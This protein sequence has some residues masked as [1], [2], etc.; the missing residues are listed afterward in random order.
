MLQHTVTGF[1][2]IYLLLLSYW[3]AHLRYAIHTVYGYSVYQDLQ[4][5]AHS[6]IFIE[7]GIFNEG[8]Y[9]EI[10]KPFKFFGGGEFFKKINSNLFNILF[11]VNDVQDTLNDSKG[12]FIIIIQHC[13]C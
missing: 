7:A 9:V 13:T 3:L 5:F 6:C 8:H 2:A 10:L 4:C 12:K 11:V 1:D